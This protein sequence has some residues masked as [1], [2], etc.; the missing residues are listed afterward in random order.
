MRRNLVVVLPVVLACAVAGIPWMRERARQREARTALFNAIQPVKLVNC[1]FERFG[2]AG[3]GG[4]VACRNLLD[5]ASA[6]YSYG[7]G[8]FDNWGCAMSARVKAPVHEY[9]CFNTSLPGCGGF[10]G[11]QPVFHAECVGPEKNTDGNRLFDTPAAQIARNGDAGKRLVMKMDVEGAEWPTLLA[12][13]DAT[14]NQIDQ[15]VVEFHTMKPERFLETIERLKRTFY[16]ANLHWNNAVCDS[17]LSPMT[18]PA[19]EL[20]L[21]NKELARLDPAGGVAPPNPLD[22]PNISVA[23]DCQAAR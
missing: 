5:R 20:L 13:S 23:A 15:L 12:M 4:Y 16:I 2:E 10:P 18:S 11:A 1:E 9:D 3:D 19:F 14:L 8:G 21:V 22:A 6:V 7:I 17:S